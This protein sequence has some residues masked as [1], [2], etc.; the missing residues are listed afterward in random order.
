MFF[1]NPSRAAA[2]TDST[3]NYLMRKSYFALSYSRDR[4]IPNWVSWH[5]YSLDLGSVSRQ[6]DFRP[7]NTLPTGWYQVPDNGYSGS[8]FDRGHNCPSADRTSTV[9]ANSSTFLMTNMIPQAPTNNQQTWARM[10]DSLRRLVTQGNEVYIIMGAYGAGGTGNNG[11]ATTIH[12]GKV[13]VP[14]NIWKVAVVINNGN[15]DS[16]RVD[17][18]T[19]VIAVMVPNTNSVSTNWKTYRT[20]VDAIEAATGYDLLTRLPVTM[21]TILEARIDNL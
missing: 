4:G 2:I 15:G 7:D 14:S 9:E 13:T 19:R 10:E 20:S 11:F 3:Q 21:Q 12:S 6:D 5:L 18:N 1:G 16:A 8:G 17:A